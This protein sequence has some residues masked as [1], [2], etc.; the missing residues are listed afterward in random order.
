[1]KK[2]LR[3]LV[4]GTALFTASNAVRAQFPTLPGGGGQRP[5]TA[6]PGT[7]SDDTPRGSAKLTGTVVDSTTNKPVE[8]AS[9]ALIETKT[10]KTIDGTVA[11]EKGK[12]TLTKL[13]EGEFQIL[14]SFVGY[15]NKT[16]SSVK[17]NRK[18]DVDL[19]AVKLAADVRTL[20][21]V[22]VVGQASLVEEKV[23]RLVY[24]ADKDITAK[25]G[26][27]TD[28]M[29]KVP[30]LSV[31]LDG[32]VSLRGSSNV[33]VLINN[34]PSTIVA[35]SVAD[36]LK[37]IP[38]D[39]IKT[40]EVI[41]SPSAKY[42]A[43]G[44]AGIINIITKKTTLQGFTLNLDS[45]VGNRGTNLGL[46]GNLR[47]GKMG[48]SLSGFGRANYNVIGKFQNTQRTFGSNGTTTTEQTADTRNNGIF[49]Q[50]TLG[51]DYDITKNS[52]ITASLRYG[53]RNNYQNQDNFL[54]R[55]TSP[56][57]YFPRLNNRN[58]LTKDLSGTVDA[59]IDY[60][61]TYA[62]PQQELSVSAQYSRNN[63]NNDFTADILS[64]SDFATIVSRQQ[65]LNN[66]Y[67]QE[68]TIQGDYQTP[69]GKNQLIE[70]GGKGIFRQVESSFTYN[71][72][73]G[74]AELLADPS[75]SG[76]TLNYDQT[77]GAG[78]VSYTLTTKNK[79]TIK[80]GTRFEHTTINA[81]YSQTQPGEQG[82]AAGQDLGIPNYSNLVP[83]VNISKALKGGKTVKL[84]YNRRLQRPGIQ[85]LNPNINAA[86]PT[87]I[88]QGNPLLSPELTDNLE[89]SSSA[90]I[91][92]VYVNMSLFARQTN[93]SITS[94]RDTVR[95]SVGQV[96]NPALAQVI[97]TTYLNIG[98]ESAYG[99]NIFGNA[100]L[101]SK[102][103]IGGGFD[104]YYAYLTNNSAMSIYNATN[105]GW[106]IT[107][108]LF[109]NLT[110]KNGWGIQGFGFARGRQVQLQGYQGGFAFYSLGVKK[111]LKD[112]RG[113]IGIAGENFLNNP[114]TI[115]SESS[116]PI[117]AQNSITSL[118][119]A[120]IRVNFNYKFGKLSFDQPQRRRGRSVDNDD[121][122]AGEGG[123]GGN[124]PQQQP[125]Q[126]GNRGGGRPR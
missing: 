99:A 60:T 43:E 94:V 46:N 20:K 34:K 32:N 4:V 111:D 23:D 24:N 118:Y 58:V 42:D 113:S 35:S 29:R 61:R 6:I 126:G 121:I 74:T 123:D 115:R 9:I 31:D 92:S 25:G 125:A 70:F 10:K 11:D 67:N 13:P 40:V 75:R 48:F 82:G 103:Q 72:G 64:S 100:T 19:G 21:E 116:S 36:A 101:F 54:T 8:F 77:I 122:K 71:L 114:F 66:S 120:G 45:G 105:S 97:R 44:S 55:T 16:L 30:L 14:I 89:L 119:N 7:A 22:E 57:D 27:A 91:K 51:W 84:A 33:R 109:T 98:K 68:T 1:M 18:G 15:R 38:A 96:N 52:A 17:L 56:N 63:R 78:Y 2:V 117:F 80:A 5:A 124:Q 108:R 110:L 69:I 59:N 62:K 104:L 87:N 85:F 41:T 28:V 12:F 102:W 79:Y 81:N 3:V 65:N 76:N 95:S 90:Y 26:D 106:V 112:K 37:Q 86:N 107:G 47:T 39:M 93:N 73:V 83:S 50:Y 49:G 88:T 53:A